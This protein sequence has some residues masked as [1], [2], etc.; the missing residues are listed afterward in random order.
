MFIYFVIRS[1]PMRVPTLSTALAVALLAL[2]APPARAYWCYLLLDAKNAVIYR[3][4]LPPVDMSRRGKAAREALRDRGDLLLIM[5][6]NDCAPEGSA[7][8]PTDQSTSA[9]AAFVDRARPVMTPQAAASAVS[10]TASEGVPAPM[11]APSPATPTQ[12]LVVPA[13]RGVL[14]AGIPARR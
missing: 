3:D 1:R 7:L 8:G 5:Q 9:V 10:T 11:P 13:G 14:P 2:P 6:T 4:T 12:E